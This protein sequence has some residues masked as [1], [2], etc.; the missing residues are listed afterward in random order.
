MIY[1]AYLIINQK[2][3]AFK[4]ICPQIFMPN[5]KSR[6]F[7][8]IFLLITA[9]VVITG[10]NTKSENRLDSIE[11]TSIKRKF[12]PSL[13]PSKEMAEREKIR[14][15]AK[16]L[17]LKKD[18]SKLTQIAYEYQMN[19]SKTGSGRWKLSLL[20]DGINSI[21]DN[22]IQ[23][24]SY[25]QRFESETLQWQKQYPK[26][27]VPYILYAKTLKNKAWKYRG[28]SFAK[29]VKPENWKPFYEYLKKSREYLLA[30]KEVA[31]KDPNWYLVMIDIAI[32]EGWDITSYGEL[33]QE[34]TLRFPYYRQLYLD[35]VI[36]LLPR[37]YGDNNAVENFAE[38]SVRKAEK[39]EG[40]S[41]Y[42]KVYES[43]SSY[44][45]KDYSLAEFS[46]DWEKMKASMDDWITRYPDSDEFNLNKVL[47]FTCLQK[48]KDKAKEY[49]NKMTKAPLIEI[50]ENWDKFDQCQIFALN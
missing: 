21:A 2:Y 22:E 6:L 34:A 4:L 29:E 30:N 14:Q 47:Y 39:E 10:C 44:G 49:L 27:P 33:L 46:I 8:S 3:E 48:D 12:S 38:W 1:F 19:E 5:L 24:E 37:W 9:F 20:Y 13:I 50:W 25:S 17:F 16:E 7:A 42:A 32:G 23:D 41:L 35:G 36:F 11:R 31:N 40:K 45:N 18:Y 28:N 43:A 26:S 15:E